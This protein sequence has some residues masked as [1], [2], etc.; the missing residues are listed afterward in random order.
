MLRIKEL[1]IERIVI[2][3]FSILPVIDSVNGILIA[4]GLPSI[5]IVYKIFVLG[6][7]LLLITRSGRIS[8][9]VVLGCFLTVIYVGVSIAVNVYGLSGTLLTIDFP[10]KLIFNILT[11]GFLYSLWAD[12]MISGKEIDTILRVNTYMMAAVILIPY[13]LGLGNTIYAGGIG[14][15]GFF[16]SNNELSVALLILFYYSLYS[17]AC[18]LRILNVLQLLCITACVLLLNTK[19]GMIACLVGIAL[20]VLE[21]LLR[22]DAK[23]KLPIILMIAAVLFIARDFIFE[24]VR[25]FMERQTYLHGLYGGSLLDTL[26]SGRTFLLENAWNS[27]VTNDG[28]LLQLLIGNGFCAS[29]LVEMD[30]LDLFFYLGI[31]GVSAFVLFLCFVF[32]KS[33]PHFRADCTRMRPFGFLMIMGYAFLA[34]HTLFMATSGCYFVLFLCFCL[35]Y[36]PDGKESTHGY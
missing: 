33:L 1:T 11:F 31:I 4:Q 16:Y 17:V 26:V 30:F 6:V 13:V 14:Y 22:K 12:G 9:A 5:G 18:K 29:V 24:Q 34:G 7:L 21:Y 8:S 15:K 10:V 19:S 36:R 28:M 23:Y 2:F 35:M 25:S 27:M 20:Y 3:L 32:Y